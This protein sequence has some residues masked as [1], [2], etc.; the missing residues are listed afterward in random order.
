MINGV[1]I[2]L[3]LSF[4][5]VKMLKI[6]EDSI[7]NACI[8][9]SKRYLDQYSLVYGNELVSNDVLRKTIFKEFKRE[10]V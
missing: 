4:A 3:P 5:R 1:N 8:R 7:L 9:I 2:L 6:D 10:E